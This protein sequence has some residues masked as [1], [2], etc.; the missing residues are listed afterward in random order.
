MLPLLKYAA[1]NLEDQTFQETQNLKT[2]EAIVKILS[3]FTSQLKNAWNGM[4]P[5]YKQG[6]MDVLYNPTYLLKL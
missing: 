6:N 4:N 2:G 5:A 3:T 1:G